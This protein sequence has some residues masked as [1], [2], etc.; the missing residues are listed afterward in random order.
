[1]YLSE[2]TGVSGIEILRDA[3]FESLGFV[4]TDTPQLLV[5][6][7]AAKY[8]PELL[9]NPL[10]S[11]VLATPE[12]AE[13]IPPH[14]G[15]MLADSPRTA[16][17][18]LHNRLAEIDF[19][20]A[21][22]ASTIDASARVHPRA[23]VAETGVR[24]GARC[25]IE[26]HATVLTGSVLCDDVIIRAGAVIGGEGF[27]FAVEADRQILAVAH[28]GGVW[29][30]SGVEVQHNTVIDKAVFG[31]YTFIGANCK[32]DNLVHIAH[33]VRLGQRNRVVAGAM[34]AGSVIAGDDVWF[35]PMCAV[36]NGVK[37][38]AGANISLGAVVTRDVEPGQRVSGNFAIDHGKLISH[39]RTIR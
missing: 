18:A 13:R 22:F 15:V 38:G 20:G 34:I 5:F 21:P 9:R 7:E 6:I 14:L 10:V 32:I 11:A 31:G 23:F 28:A 16:F 19:Y 33:A 4:S 2:V 30:Q 12:L 1:M 17:Y 36:S 27:Q 37:V 8:L 3:T 39:L 25:V 29:L 35:G 26:P 24:I